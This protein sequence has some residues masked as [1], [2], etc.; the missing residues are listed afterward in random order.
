MPGDSDGLFAGHLAED[1]DIIVLSQHNRYLRMEG[2]VWYRHQ[3]ELSNNERFNI[4][5]II[6]GI[7]TVT[8]DIFLLDATNNQAIAVQVWVLRQ[9]I[10]IDAFPARKQRL[11]CEREKRETQKVH[12][13]AEH[14]FQVSRNLLRSHV[15]LTASP[16][17]AR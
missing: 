6:D 8:S 16:S 12:V 7:A 10:A 15:S 13:S 2:D 5:K 14:T 17:R 3:D 4:T 11:I 1:I 9:R